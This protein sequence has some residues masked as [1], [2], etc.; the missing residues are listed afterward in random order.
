MKKRL[1]PLILS[2]VY[3]SMDIKTKMMNIPSYP[4]LNCKTA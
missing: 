2:L 3:L 1:L 4:I